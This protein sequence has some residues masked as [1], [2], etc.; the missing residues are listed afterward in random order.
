MVYRNENKV[1]SRF[2]EGEVITDGNGIIIDQ[3]IE[4]GYTGR[5][6]VANNVVFDNGGRGILVLES[7]RVDVMYNTTYNNGR[8]AGLEGGPV[9]LVAARADDVRLLNNLAWSRSG[10]PAVAVADA[11]NVV[12]GGNVF[13][14]DSPSGLATDTDLVAAEDPGLVRPSIDPAI[15]DF[16]PGV[17]STVI[18]RALP[19][20]PF[21]SFDADGR[22]RNAASP[23][24]GAYE[25]E[26]GAG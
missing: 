22:S 3:A 2:R 7:N 12:L 5:V 26:S 17:G 1:F 14:T 16:R 21:V 20:D 4:T 18:D 9:E 10:A 13:V 6:L 8:T 25:F 19:V 24:V 23:D 11:S 15:A